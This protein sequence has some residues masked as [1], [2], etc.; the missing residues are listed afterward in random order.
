MAHSQVSKAL[1]INCKWIPLRIIQNPDKQSQPWMISPQTISFICPKLISLFCFK[2]RLSSLI[3]DYWNSTPLVLSWKFWWESTF[4]FDAICLS[5]IWYLTIYPIKRRS[6]LW[7]LA[8]GKWIMIDSSLDCHLPFPSQDSR[9]I[10]QVASAFK[11]QQSSTNLTSFSV[12][13]P[14]LVISYAVAICSI[15][16][17]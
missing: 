14:I 10:K 16:S 13:L 9:N 15:S 4:F 8:L 17:S 11:Q 12:C 7:L 1:K 2:Q 6:Y 3:N 5:S